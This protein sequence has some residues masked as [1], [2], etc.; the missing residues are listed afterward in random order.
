M[1]SRSE[2]LFNELAFSLICEICKN[3][4]SCIFQK[5]LKTEIDSRSLGF[6]V[7][8]IPNNKEYYSP[9]FRESLGYRDTKDFPNVPQSWMDAIRPT[10]L[11]LALESYNA[12]VKTGGKHQYAQEVVYNKKN[13]GI[14]KL[15]CH[16]KVVAWEDEKPK[17]MI[18]VH[19]PV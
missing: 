9:S 12:H 19:L 3:D 7:W 11:K 16:G 10:S 8:D 6:W 1:T 2:L 18:G 17:I 15:I 14:V 4:I 13:G 5:M